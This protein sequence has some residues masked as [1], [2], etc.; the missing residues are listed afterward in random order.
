MAKEAGFKHMW[1]QISKPLLLWYLYI[2]PRSVCIKNA[3]LAIIVSVDDL[4]PNGVRPSAD[5]MLTT[6][7]GPICVGSF[8]LYEP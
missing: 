5:T 8:D 6:Q 7:L 4:T 2:M 1:L 3:Q